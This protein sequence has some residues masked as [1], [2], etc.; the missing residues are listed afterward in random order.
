MNSLSLILRILAVVAAVAAGAIFFV[1]KGKLAEKEA[2]L[3]SAQKATQA[4]QAELAT[5]N[6]KIQG[7]ESRLNNEREALADSKRKLESVRSEM[8]T[9]RQEVSRTQQQLAKSK[10]TISDLESTAQRLR[11]DLVQTEQS[12]VAANKEGEISQF[13]ERI[14]ELEESNADLKESLE[15]AKVRS[16]SSRSIGSTGS[17]ATGPAALSSVFTTGTSQ[18]LPTAS[19]SIGPETT[20]HS[21]SAENGLVVLTNTPELGLS[22]GLEVRLIRDLKAIGQIKFIQIT[23]QIAVAN[24]LPGSK[25]REMVA[26]GTVNLMR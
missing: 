23:D 16:V 26:G 25:S 6:E 19:A 4:T 5:A 13:N 24:I 14:A 11:A 8:Y 12:L 1:S 22:P 3:Q 2:A 21:V 9:A 17:P 15:D 18:A 7:L 10:K 20:I